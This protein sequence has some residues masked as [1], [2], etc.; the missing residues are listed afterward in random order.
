MTASPLRLLSDLRRRCEAQIDRDGH[1]TSESAIVQGLR[2]SLRYE[3]GAWSLE[4]HVWPLEREPVA[5]D[6]RLIETAIRVLGG[7]VTVAAPRP[8]ATPW[9]A[10]RWVW[11]DLE[12]TSKIAAIRRASMSIA[13]PGA[14]A[15]SAPSDAPCEHRVPAHNYVAVEGGRLF[16][17][18]DWC[19]LAFPLDPPTPANWIF[20]RAPGQADKCGTCGNLIIDAVVC[21]E[22]CAREMGDRK[23]WE[24]EPLSTPPEGA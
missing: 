16:M 11:R 7:P 19:R 21:G 15:V 8:G 12:P 24:P 5:A 2:F 3:R 13:F 1:S 22:R 9:R 17:K 18:C 4:A 14:N 10:Q 20:R 6:F 23:G